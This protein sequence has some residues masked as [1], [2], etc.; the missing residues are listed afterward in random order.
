MEVQIGSTF[1]FAVATY[2]SIDCFVYTEI[3]KSHCNGQHRD[4]FLLRQNPNN[5]VI[6]HCIS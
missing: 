1:F 3:L 6:D 2:S 5:D 4:L